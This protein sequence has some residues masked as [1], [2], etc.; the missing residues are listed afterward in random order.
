[1]R[2]EYAARLR[3]GSGSHQL[4]V[5]PNQRR[6]WKYLDTSQAESRIGRPEILAP[7]GL[8]DRWLIDLWPDGWNESLA[9]QTRPSDLTVEGSQYILTQMLREAPHRDAFV[10]LELPP[11]RLAIE[12]IHAGNRIAAAGLSSMTRPAACWTH[13]QIGMMGDTPR[14]WLFSG[15]TRT[16]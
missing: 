10:Q 6:R 1:M 16:T 14:S 13:L 15:H 4:V 12:I 7:L 3:Q 5:V 11:N 9:P 8:A 2:D